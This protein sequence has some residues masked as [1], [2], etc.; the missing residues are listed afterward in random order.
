MEASLDDAPIQPLRGLLESSSSCILTVSRD[1]SGGEVVTTGRG[2]GGGITFRA[3]H[4]SGSRGETRDGGGGGSAKLSPPPE[5]GDDDIGLS[6]REDVGVR[7]AKGEGGLAAAVDVER[8]RLGGERGGAFRST[9]SR[10]S[11][12]VFR[13]PSGRTNLVG[14]TVVTKAEESWVRDVQ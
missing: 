10:I 1:S 2:A 5:N 8:R 7:R 12:H 13:S 6:R 11:S 14:C 4:D 3:D 9:S